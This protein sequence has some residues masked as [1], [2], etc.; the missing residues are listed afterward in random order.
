MMSDTNGTVICSIMQAMPTI[1]CFA[2]DQSLIRASKSALPQWRRLSPRTGL[3]LDRLR[4]FIP[5]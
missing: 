2:S 3:E 1:H 5:E 4:P